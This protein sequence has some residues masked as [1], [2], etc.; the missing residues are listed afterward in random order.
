MFT[1]CS[2]LPLFSLSFPCSSRSLSVP[3]GPSRYLSVPLGTSR[4]L[5][6]P[7][8]TSRYLSVLLWHNCLS[9][10]YT[11]LYCTVLYSTVHCTV[12]PL[13]LWDSVPCPV[14]FGQCFCTALPWHRAV[15]SPSGLCSALHCL[16]LWTALL[17]C[18][19]GAVCS[20]LP[21]MDTMLL[22]SHFW[23]TMLCSAPLLV[24]C[25]A[26]PILGFALF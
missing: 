22:Y 7:L 10:L 16:R 1:R 12:A 13:P 17:D 9:A 26:Q 8:G 18:P 6:V 5:S 20:A 15:Y 19:S 2:T 11:A 3:L 23:G 21:M 24:L 25:S 4:H 14:H